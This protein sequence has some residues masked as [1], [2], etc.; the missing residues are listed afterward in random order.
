YVV[1][2]TG[3]EGGGGEGMF[4]C[5]L[6]DRDTPGLEWQ[7]E[8][9]GFGMRSNSSRSVRLDAVRVPARNLLGEQGDQLWYVFE[10][11]A[12]YFLMAMAGTYTGVARAA[13]E[14]ARLHLLERR[15]A[16]TGELLG[17]TPVLAHRLGDLWTEVERTRQ[18]VYSAAQRADDGDAE[19]LIAVLA[20]KAAAG[21]TAVRVANEA[22]T[23]LGGMG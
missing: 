3:V 7:G 16:H 12:P 22:M 19:S 20:C 10:V 1:S 18:L 13:L 6:V 23:L 5:V 8:W 14:E 4:S 9:H 2:T 15:H 17:A 21:D 11:V